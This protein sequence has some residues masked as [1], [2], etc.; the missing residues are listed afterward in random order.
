MELKSSH[1]ALAGVII[2]FGDQLIITPSHFLV[3]ASKDKWLVWSNN[4]TANIS[5]TIIMVALFAMLC[6]NNKTKIAGAI[7]SILFGTWFITSG[8]VGVGLS[9]VLFLLAYP[10]QFTF[11]FTPA[12]LFIVAGWRYLNN[13]NAETTK[14]IAELKSKIF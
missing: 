4:L 12:I 13:E 5:T 11:T 9:A 2:R 3:A 10:M 1:I 6:I 8:L 7:L 14:K